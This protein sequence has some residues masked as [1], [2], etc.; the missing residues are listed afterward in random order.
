M[1]NIAP[2]AFQ[3]PNDLF[4]EI[5]KRLHTHE[6]VIYSRKD[7][8]YH[9]ILEV[10]TKERKIGRIKCHYNKFFRCTSVE[11]IDAMDDI[12]PLLVQ[13]FPIKKIKDNQVDELA[14]YLIINYHFE[15]HIIHRDRVR[16]CYEIRFRDQFIWV[17]IEN[18]H[19]NS[20][21]YVQGDLDFFDEVYHI[22]IDFERIIRQTQ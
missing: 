4:H 21:T 10:G 11:M 17:N 22:Y 2:K 13:L 9:F 16:T 19:E 12:Y 6:L 14:R 7:H 18:K 20:C 15:V 5:E 8:P 3:C 1:K